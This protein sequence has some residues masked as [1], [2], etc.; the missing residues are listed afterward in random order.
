MSLLDEYN[1]SFFI[2]DKVRVPDGLGG[3]TTT[4]TESVEIEGALAPASETE[5]KTAEAMKEKVTNV[6]ITSKLNNLDY[7]D[8]L[9]RKE[10]GQIY[11][12]TAAGA[13]IVTP[14]SSSLNLRKYALE[15]WELPAEV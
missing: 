2:L 11:R 7:H 5:I 14:G 13:E 12:V 15:A 9:R 4:Y 8:V 3:Y 6:L 1:E 10:D